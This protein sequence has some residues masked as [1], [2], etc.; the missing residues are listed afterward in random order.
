M[1]AVNQHTVQKLRSA[2]QHHPQCSAEAVA[3]DSQT[4]CHIVDGAAGKVSEQRRVLHAA[5]SLQDFVEGT[6]A[7]GE[8]HAVVVCGEFSDPLGEISGTA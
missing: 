4:V 3:G 6:V 2:L 1:T 7:A 5:D 8:N